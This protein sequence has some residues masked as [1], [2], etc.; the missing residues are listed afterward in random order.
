MRLLRKLADD[1]GDGFSF[2]AQVVGGRYEE[3]EMNVH[4]RRS[5]R[6]T[7]SVALERG[8]VATRR[9]NL[10]LR[11]HS[12]GAATNNAFSSIKPLGDD[13][14]LLVTTRAIVDSDIPTPSATSGTIRGS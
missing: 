3:I 10:C 9:E 12:V 14:Y 4:P 8:S 11:T 6:S 1:L 13:K 2:L 7:G 5:S